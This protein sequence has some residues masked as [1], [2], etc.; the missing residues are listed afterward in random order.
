M[1]LLD[2]PEIRLQ[3]QK[4]VDEAIDLQSATKEE[5]QKEVG[6]L[7]KEVLAL[8]LVLGTEYAK[9]TR[10]PFD[11]I[12]VSSLRYSGVLEGIERELDIPF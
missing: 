1:S 4:I 6:E 2:M 5:Y 9:K 8:G 3:I 12:I 7:I 11:D 10:N